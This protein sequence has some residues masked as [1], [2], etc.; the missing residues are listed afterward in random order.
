MAINVGEK[1]QKKKG[2]CLQTA[3]A[4]HKA[5]AHAHTKPLPSLKCPQEAT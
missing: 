3:K 5:H 4:T 2:I 1:T